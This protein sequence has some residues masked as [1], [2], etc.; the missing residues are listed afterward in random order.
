VSDLAEY[1]D[2]MLVDAVARRDE[3]ALA[4]IY[5]RHARIAYSLAYRVVADHQRAEDIVQEAFVKLWRQPHLYQP[6]RGTFK[7]WFLQL[8]RNR[9]VDDVRAGTHEVVPA[10][11]GWADW[12]W[13]NLP[14]ADRDPAEKAIDSL[15][16]EVVFEALCSLPTEQRAAIEL[17]YYGGMTQSE[18]ARELRAPLGTVK[19]R[20]RA[21]M[22]RLRELLSPLASEG[23]G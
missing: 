19:T 13:S 14:A 23:G 20:I 16:G 15:T 21:G 18:I 17:A 3:G 12:F 9:S 8:V 4:A 11:E 6:E 2:E 1:T 22:L 7:N 10:G 5:D